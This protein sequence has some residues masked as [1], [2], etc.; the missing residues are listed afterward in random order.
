MK[1]P[2]FTLVELMITL[3]L[4]ALVVGLTIVNVSFLDRG[5]V[6]S[7]VD[8]L[9]SACMYTQQCAL[10]MGQQY[11]L[12]FDEQ[13]NSYTFAGKTERLRPPVVF[14]VVAGAKGPPSSPS[15]KI[16]K[17]I[18]FKH[19]K[20]LFG[21]TGSIS[22]GTVYL[23]D[24]KRNCLYALSNGIAQVSH[25]RKYSYTGTWKLLP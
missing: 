20:I 12:V 2:G 1:S 14:G 13:N 22:S 17:P 24:A 19:K 23:T 10:A 7:E 11:E 3:A 25:L 5:I 15:K 16:T 21:P 4:C 18:T 8:K 6:R 9:Y